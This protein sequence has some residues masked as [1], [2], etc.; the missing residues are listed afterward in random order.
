MPT[1]DSV[2]VRSDSASGATA[3][4]LSTHAIAHDEWLRYR[5]W[6]RTNLPWL[7]KFILQYQDA[8]T[9]VEPHMAMFQALQKFPGGDDSQDKVVT[10]AKLRREYKPHTLM[11]DL[12]NPSPQRRTLILESRLFLKTSIAVIG[13][14]IQWI[15]NFPNVRVLISSG[16]GQLV[17]ASALLINQHFRVN[18][19][20]RWLFPEH[21]PQK[22]VEKFGS[23]IGMTTLART[24]ILR[25]PTISTTSVGAAIA[26]GHHD[27]HKHDDVVDKENVRTAESIAMVNAH[28]Q[29]TS[30]LLDRH[31]DSKGVVMPGWTDFI[32]TRYD[33]SDAYG[34]I[35]DSE[36]SKTPERRVYSIVYQPAWRGTWGTED[37]KATWPQK[38]TLDQLKAIEDDPL[39]GPDVLASQY[40]L[41][42]RP[43]KSGLLDDRK[44]IR[45]TPRK[46]L[47]DLYPFLRLHVT[48]DL[49]GMEATTA[50]NKH[51]DN[52]FTAINLSGFARDGHCYVLELFH[53][54]PTPME[55]IDYIF[56]LW[57]RHPRIVDFKVPKDLLGRVLLPFLAREQTK[58]QKFLPIV[59]IA[60]NNRI[61]KKQKIKGLQ[62]WFR[63][64]IISFA[65]DL[66]CRYQLEEEIIRFPVYA[67][68]DLLDTIV[69]Q[70]ENRQGGVESDT[71]HNV[72]PAPPPSYGLLPGS[73]PRFQ[74]FGPGGTEH[75]Q[76]VEED[77][78]VITQD[79]TT[80][81]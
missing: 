48:L 74:G 22:T 17:E 50:Q 49:H 81:L 12:Y 33:F 59:P 1:P 19:T 51:A 52:D 76:G 53:G 9:E 42:P 64:G 7:C 28:I 13:H 55:V 30:P 41:R 38:V 75:W 60:I 66:Q 6:A 25:D 31:E 11:W 61:S 10:L 32:G 54:R 45:F 8:S 35:L 65:E 62:P 20:F 2:T 34:Q 40:G 29:A 4:D 58:R 79:P 47:N 5:H 44:Q 21:V 15:I 36:K 77:T 70:M 37:C 26:G 16:T 72:L 14:I 43:G 23:S 24:S 27:V 56:K 73:A 71:L 39:Q 78:E 46:V 3:S 63:G 80:G 68:D 57:F 18:E 69:D 67:H